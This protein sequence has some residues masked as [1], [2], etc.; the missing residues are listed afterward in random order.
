MICNRRKQNIKKNY[1]VYLLL[2]YLFLKGLIGIVSCIL[3]ITLT[4]NS[5]LDHKFI[6]KT[7]RDFIIRTTSIDKN[8]K[9]IQSKTKRV[10]ILN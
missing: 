8:L 10:I 3:F 4:S 9:S 2:I 7:E 5:P 1:F 6:S